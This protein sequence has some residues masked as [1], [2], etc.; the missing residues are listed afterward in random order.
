MDSI[1]IDIV[2]IW[3]YI[4]ELNMLKSTIPNEGG[5]P[6]IQGSGETASAMQDAAESFDSIA[7]TLDLLV[8]YSIQFLKNAG[9]VFLTRDKELAES[10]R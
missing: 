7:Q 3:K 4:V 6:D 1:N 5:V 9:N 2:A 10:I 8:D